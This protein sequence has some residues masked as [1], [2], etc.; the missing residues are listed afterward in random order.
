MWGNVSIGVLGIFCLVLSLRF[1]WGVELEWVS[2]YLVSNRYLVNIC[3]EIGRLGG[4]GDIIGWCGVIGLY[5]EWV[6]KDSRFNE[7]IGV[8]GFVGELG[9]GFVG[10]F[11]LFFFYRW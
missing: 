9:I 8:G 2:L 6:N 5:Y 10:V 4:Y 7:W 3:G 1:F 11:S